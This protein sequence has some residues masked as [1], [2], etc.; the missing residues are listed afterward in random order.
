LKHDQEKLTVTK[1]LE[2]KLEEKERKIND[3]EAKLNTLELNSGKQ[4]KE[5]EKNFQGKIDEMNRRHDVDMNRQE[6][7]MDTL[8]SNIDTLNQFKDTK[9]IREDNLRKEGDRY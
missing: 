6:N 9:A 8:D 4:Q 7:K 5:L 2:T 3:Y 1:T